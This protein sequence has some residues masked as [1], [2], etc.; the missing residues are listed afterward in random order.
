MAD[1]IVV[2][3]AGHDKYAAAWRSMN[4]GL[5]KYWSDCPWEIYWITNHLDAPKGCR[6]IKVGGDFNPKQ[7]SNRMIRGL[8]QVPAKMILWCLDDHW[9]TAKPDIDALMDFASYI[10][11]R[12]ARRIRLYPGWDHDRSSGAF[13]YDNRLLVMDEKS[14]YRT[15]CKPSFWNRKILLS[16]LKPNESPWDFEQNGRGRSARSTFLAVKDWGHFSFV[17]KG[18][19][20]GPWAKSPIVKGKL[21]TAAKRYYEREGLKFDLKH[22]VK[23][24]P[25]GKEIPKYILP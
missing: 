8:K 24:N 14:P 4:H 2:V 25:F 16:L 20:S 17:T 9:I 23:G 13:K 3:V 19:P 7:W 6:T 15:S 11:R 5:R 12:L 1:D 22:P 10:E 21:T 18:D